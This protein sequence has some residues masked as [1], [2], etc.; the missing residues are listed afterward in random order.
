MKRDRWTGIFS[1]GC[2][3]YQQYKP[4]IFRQSLRAGMRF[5][6]F[7]LP[8]TGYMARAQEVQLQQVRVSG[9]RL[10]CDAVLLRELSLKPGDSFPA[11]SAAT[12][13]EQNLLRLQNLP[14]FT[15]VS[16]QWDTLSARQRD[17]LIVVKER[18]YIWPEARVRLADRNFNVWWQ[19]Y[20]HDLRRINAS[21]KLTHRNVRGNLEQ[22]SV[23]VQVGYTQGFTLGYQIPYLNQQ[24][25]RG[26]G[27]SFVYNRN[28]E[29]AFATDSN[30]LRL[31][32][33]QKGFLLE[34]F[35]ASV[36][37]NYR[38]AYHSTHQVFLSYHHL[39]IA[40][41]VL[42]LNPGFFPGRR[43]PHFRYLELSYRLALNYVD[44]WSYPTR[45]QKLV[46][47]IGWKQGL[48]KAD[49]YQFYINP[50]AG[51]FL[52]PLPRLLT[53][54]ILRGY[55]SLPEKQSFYL[56]A[57][58][59]YGAAYLR[60]FE[61]F[62]TEGP[63]YAIGRS[64]VK[65]EWLKKNFQNLPFRYLPSLPVAIY[66][67]VFADAGYSYQPLNHN[68]SF[69]NNKLLYSAGVGV[70]VVTAYDI[71]LRIEYVR[72]SLGQWGWFLHMDGE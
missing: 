58:M 47:Y 2:F 33:A 8:F 55:F 39:Q 9:N 13:L 63:H 5:L 35:A 21:L 32:R 26:M 19:D 34:Q 18:W 15:E 29:M 17:L 27:F 25:T 10:T 11:D 3:S 46:N 54:H 22:L 41:S 71:K 38:P 37:Y 57:G 72:N 7:L 40:D 4:A 1:Y 65:F 12:L 70:D 53:S 45:G 49:G 66:P 51:V 61:R 31:A 43:K 52:Q 68:R 56:N 23:G 59:G 14:L 36:N 60:G 24:Q 62:V 30:K 16:L 69:L 44:N 6:F 20:N 48:D 42:E 67:K 64:S 50:E 28:Q